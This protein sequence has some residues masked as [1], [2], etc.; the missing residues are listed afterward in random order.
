MIWSTKKRVETTPALPNGE[1]MVYDYDDG[2]YLVS[3][4]RTMFDAIVSN[5]YGHIGFLPIGM[6]LRDAV[7]YWEEF[8]KEYNAV[9]RTEQA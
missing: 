4:H 7:S 9:E 8:K 3:L 1:W 5:S 6:N 2:P